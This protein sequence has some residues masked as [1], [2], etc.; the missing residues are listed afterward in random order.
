METVGGAMWDAA[1]A[2]Y[3]RELLGRCN[4][5]AAYAVL[6]SVGARNLTQAALYLSKAQGAWIAAVK[7][8]PLISELYALSAAVIALSTYLLAKGNKQK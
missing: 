5:G 4:A 6:A 2:S 1:T 3:V 8:V 7:P